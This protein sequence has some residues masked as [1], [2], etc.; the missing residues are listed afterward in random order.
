MSEKGKI[1]GWTKAVLIGGGVAGGIYALYRLGTTVFAAGPA[2]A[3]DK[4]NYWTAEYAKELKAITDQNRLPSASEEYALNKKQ[5]MID[6]AYN[7]LFTVY[8]VARD[9]LIAGIAAVAAIYL[10][11]RLARSYWNTHVT[12]TQTPASAVEL[13]RSAYAVDLYATG[14]TG[15]GV[16]LQDQ[17]E[18]VFTSLATPTFEAEIFGLQTQIAT[19]TGNQ[20]L[21]TQLLVQNLQLELASTIPTI[22]TAAS[23]ILALPPPPF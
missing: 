11:S 4:L 18:A 5:G 19:L 8:G 3:L 9:V 16:A 6:Q 2:A 17:T 20:L 1:P 7:E 15:L 22:L 10:I 14:H 21:L 23:Q 13:L 12:D